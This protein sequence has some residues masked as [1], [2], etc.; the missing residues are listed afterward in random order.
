MIINYA[1]IDDPKKKIVQLAKI[2][3]KGGGYSKGKLTKHRVEGLMKQLRT[4]ADFEKVK[5]VNVK[6]VKANSFDNAI[7]KAF[8]KMKLV[9]D[10]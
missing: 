1:V 2:R 5:K 7:K 6:F 3:R 10:L 4:K 9:K 8:P